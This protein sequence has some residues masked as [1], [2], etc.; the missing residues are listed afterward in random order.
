MKNKLL[1]K[2]INENQH[3]K[4]VAIQGLGFVGSAMSLVCANPLNGDYAVIGVEL[5][6]KNGKSIY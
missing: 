5:P 6:N 3:R 1:Q 2:F 4:I